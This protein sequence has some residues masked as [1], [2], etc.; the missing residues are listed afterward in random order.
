MNTR[1]HTRAGLITGIISHLL[2]LLSTWMCRLFV[3]P[4]GNIQEG[5]N[6]RTVLV[7]SSGFLDDFWLYFS[8]TRRFVQVVFI[9][10]YSAVYEFVCVCAC[11]CARARAKTSEPVVSHPFT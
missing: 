4:M 2:Q 9:S 6:R 8:R 7:S 5:D 3:W 1:A 11:V 10:C